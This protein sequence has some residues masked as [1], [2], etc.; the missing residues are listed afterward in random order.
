MIQFDDIDIY[1]KS[2][3]NIA[4][5]LGRRY[6]QYRIALGLT[7]KDVA[8]HAGMSVM[9]IVRFEK[10][11]V[12]SIGLD[13]FIALMRAVQILDNINGVI[14]DIPQSLYTIKQPKEPQRVRRK[15]DE[16]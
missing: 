2:N 8:S 15:R 7:Q 14:P 3:N 13:K 6:R 16:K 9:T 12:T 10:G 11:E 5:D 4:V 1:E